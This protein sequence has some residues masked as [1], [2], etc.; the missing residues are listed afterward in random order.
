V[1]QFNV[2]F[3]KLE[4]TEVIFSRKDVSSRKFL[5]AP[6]SYMI[7][8]VLYILVHLNSFSMQVV[9]MESVIKTWLRAIWM[10]QS[11]SAPGSGSK[12]KVMAPTVK[13]LGGKQPRVQKE[14]Q[15]LCYIPI[16]PFW[17]C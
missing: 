10:R 14:R 1:S 11:G 7:W 9:S 3:P 16:T 8:L 5:L 12:E 2:G 4:V 6:D 17:K 15:C 13:P